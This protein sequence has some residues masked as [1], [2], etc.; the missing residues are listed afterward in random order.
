[1]DHDDAV[2]EDG[3]LDP[4]GEDL[5]QHTQRRLGLVEDPLDFWIVSM[6]RW[7]VPLSGN[8]EVLVV[9]LADARIHDNG[10]VMNSHQVFRT[11]AV[12]DKCLDHAV[13]LPGTGR[14]AVVV[15]LP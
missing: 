3:D 15:D 4:I 1:M 6:H 5:V 10:S 2:E 8:R 7:N 11:V 13:E 14:A 12:L 9:D